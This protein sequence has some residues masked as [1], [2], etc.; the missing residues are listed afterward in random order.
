MK[1]NRLLLLFTAALCHAAGMTPE[2]QRLLGI[3]TATLA[4]ATLPPQASAY[5]TAISPAPLI[6]LFRQAATAHSA[7]ASSQESLKRA[8][9]LF[10]SG[11]LIA[12]KELQAA[13]TQAT[14]DQAAL[15]LLEDRLQLEWGAYFSK[16]DAGARLE[17]LTELLARKKSLL[18]L[19]LPRGE[20]LVPLAAQFQALRCTAIFPAPAVDVAA[21]SQAFYGIVAADIAVGAA[22]SGVIELAGVVRA[23]FVIPSDAVVFYLGKAWIYQPGESEGFERMEIPTS[24]PVTGGFFVCGEFSKIVSKG[25]QAL[26]SQETLAPAEGE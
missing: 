10:A 25:A 3:E 24:L 19:T 21:Q 26:L 5:A 16:L 17:L 8:E 1:I 14:L 11:A 23:G 18:R 20:P 2:T 6:D 7:I 22:L 12:R 9:A 13:Q 4:E 15:Q